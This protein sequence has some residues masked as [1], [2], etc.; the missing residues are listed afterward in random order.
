ML[1]KYL[2]RDGRV[3]LAEEDGP[4]WVYTNPDEAEK[5]FLIDEL[6]LDEHTLSSALDPDELA[7]LEFEPEHAA[8]IMKRPLSYSAE[9]NFNFKVTSIGVFLFKTRLVV[10]QSKDLPMFEGKTFNKVGSLAGVALATLGRSIFHFREHLKVINSITDELEQKALVAMENKY[11][12][13]LFVLEKS[14]VYY[15]NAIN[16]NGALLERLKNSANRLE[17]SV[18]SVEQLD[19]T[20]IENAQCY[21]QAEIYSNI[22]ASLMDARASLVSNNLN[23]LMKTLNIVTIAIMVPTLVVSAFSM[24]VPI[25]QQREPLAFWGIILLAV[26]SMIGVLGF[27][28][29]KHWW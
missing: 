1:R 12:V 9:D 19:D 13:H 6:R 22:L 7:R 16:S 15:L 5:R 28:K 11:L 29:R 8:L 3:A 25:P 2:I 21:K 27:W 10:V 20:A 14:L 4:I 23:V 26:F 17:F 18:E 24:N